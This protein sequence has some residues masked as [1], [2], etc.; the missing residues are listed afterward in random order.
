MQSVLERGSID[1]PLTFDVGLIQLSFIPVCSPNTCNISV[2]CAEGL[3][4]SAFHYYKHSFFPS[5]I[6]LWNS[7]P[8]SAQF[9][10]SSSF[11]HF[12]TNNL[13]I[14]IYC[15]NTN[16]SYH[17]SFQSIFFFFAIINIIII[18]LF[19][20]IIMIIC[21]I[22]SYYSLTE[23]YYCLILSLFVFVLFVLSLGK[24]SH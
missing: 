8:S 21:I 16:I 14:I 22:S 9:S 7:L 4:F 18:V 11:K 3:H 23:P 24:P 19:F 2:N 17:N 1:K 20:S 6:S 10:V 13:L 15:N 12:F 5:I